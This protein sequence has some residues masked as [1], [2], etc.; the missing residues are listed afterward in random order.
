MPEPVIVEVTSEPEMVIVE[1]VV[2]EVPSD[3][4]AA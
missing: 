4:D 1:T 3:N 2:E